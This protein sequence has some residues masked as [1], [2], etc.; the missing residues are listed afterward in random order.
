MGRDATRAATHEVK[1]IALRFGHNEHTLLSVILIFTTV[2]RFVWLTLNT[3][4]VLGNST[5]DPGT[6]L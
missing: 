6:L 5:P 3:N 4:A 2:R 1:R